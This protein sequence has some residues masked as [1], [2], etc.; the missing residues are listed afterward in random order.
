MEKN[1]I[2]NIDCIAGMGMIPDHS[3]DMIL[4]DLPYGITACRWDSIIPFPI[5][6]REYE[7]IIK[8][9]GAIVLTACQPFTTDLIQSNRKL[10]RYCWYWKKNMVTGYAN[11]KRQPL[12]CIEDIVVFYKQQPTY[13]PQ[14]LI[15]LDKPYVRTK[16]NPG[17]VYGTASL[18]REYTVQ[19]SHYPKQLLEFNCQRDGLHP[20][21]K[22]VDLFEYLIRT[23]T[24]AGDIVLDNCMGCGT[25]AIACLR[26]GR[27]FTGF[28][29]EE[30]YYKIAVERV[31]EFK[32]SHSH[33][34]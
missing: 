30:K 17:E 32:R 33:A 9:N 26:S 4:C 25:T 3:I 27:E 34:V 12:R 5:L 24:N 22:P 10:F 28:E 23:Y 20:T 11:A 13:N 31:E 14:G 2:H 21:Q 16:N 18:C 29:I 1:A 15:A 6:W 7:R 8:Q 19:Y